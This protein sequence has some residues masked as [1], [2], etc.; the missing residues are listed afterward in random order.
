VK[1]TPEEMAYD[2]SP[3]ET[4]EWIPVGRGPAAIFAKPSWKLKMVELEPD[5]AE[6]FKDS[7]AVNRAL[8]K[9]IAAV[10]GAARRKK[11][12]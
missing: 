8:R 2:P 1:F 11:S 9:L 4:A 3:E 10:P 12:A 6:V 7:K 5:V